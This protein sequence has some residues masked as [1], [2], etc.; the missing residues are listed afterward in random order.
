MPPPPTTIALLLP[1]APA[2][3]S[4]EAT[5]AYWA[6]AIAD[7]Y[8]RLHAPHAALLYIGAPAPFSTARRAATFCAAQQLLTALY[9][10]V[11][12][13]GAAHVDARVVLLAA[14]DAPF[15]PV[16]SVAQLADLHEW[17]LLLVARSADGYQ[18]Q[19]EFLAYASSASVR[20]NYVPAGTEPAGAAE[21]AG[22][23]PAGAA[24]DAG[25][26]PADHTVVAGRCARAREA[27]PR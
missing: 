15:G 18:Q 7:A 3:A 27:R 6:P 14:D 4:A 10:L 22:A 25:A 17:D 5:A 2:G 9:A 12:A 26:E 11:Y 16:L 19:G 1:A 13:H 20:V 24:E 21:D 23:E 8:A